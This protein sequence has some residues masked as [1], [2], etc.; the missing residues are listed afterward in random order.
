M[1]NR[2]LMAYK[3]AEVGTASK[4]KLVIMMYDGAIRFLNECKK[5]IDKGDIAGR[6]LYIS[7]AQR[8]VSELQDSL[9]IQQGGEIALQLE[10]LY[11]F[12]IHNIT[13]ANLKG[14]KMYIDQSIA[15]L[16]NLRDAWKQVMG[17]AQ[18]RQMEDTARTNQ[19]VAI[20]L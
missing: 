17:N 19:K 15:V 3:T 9:N 2:Q 16:E 4:I 1:V 18:A 8:I 20:Q 12:L 14:E 11:T 13:K 7:K 10:Q 6:G 5:R